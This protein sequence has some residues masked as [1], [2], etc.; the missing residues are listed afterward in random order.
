[1]FIGAKSAALAQHGVYQRGFSV[2]N[3]RD[4]CDI[5]NTGIQIGIRLSVLKR[6]GSLYSIWKSALARAARA[7]Q[8]KKRTA[9]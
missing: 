8:K 5:T 7:R 9:L 2:I 3:V 1:V 4:N 6:M